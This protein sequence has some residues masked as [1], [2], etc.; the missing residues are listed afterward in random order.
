M[1][2]R[3]HLEFSSDRRKFIQMNWLSEFHLPLP[4]GRANQ[5]KL[6]THSRNSSGPKR[7]TSSKPAGPEDSSVWLLFPSVWFSSWVTFREPFPNSLDVIPLLWGQDFSVAPC[8]SEREVLRH[9]SRG[10]REKP[11][12]CRWQGGRRLRKMTDSGTAFALS[13]ETE[14]PRE[15]DAETCWLG[16]HAPGVRLL[17]E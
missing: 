15:W 10:L 2:V 9:F 1:P 12:Q 17:V 13:T 4:R 8:R 11:H 14:T 3:G 5:A 16:L 6:G 7:Q